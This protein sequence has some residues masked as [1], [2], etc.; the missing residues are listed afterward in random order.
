MAKILGI[1]ALFILLILMG[2]PIVFS[3]GV[4]SLTAF[5]GESMYFTAVAQ[6]T[7]FLH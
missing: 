7:V 2:L 3:M 6:K 4:L 1:L 5:V